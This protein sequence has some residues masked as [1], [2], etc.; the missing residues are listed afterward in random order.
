MD[1]Q[2]STEQMAAFPTDFTAI[3][4]KCM[5]EFAQAQGEILGEVQEL[6]QEW[7]N[8]LQSEAKMASEFGSKLTKARS[9]ADAVAVY[10]DWNSKRLECAA[11]D[12][13]RLFGHIQKSMERGARLLSSGWLAKNGEISS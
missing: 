4:Q 13:K 6:S 2:T 5:Q 12:G 9:I 10:Q 8:R 11:D 1:K 3:S 7:A